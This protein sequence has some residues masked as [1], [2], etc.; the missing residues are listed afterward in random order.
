MTRKRPPGYELLDNERH[1]Y[2]QQAARWRPSGE[3]PRINVTTCQKTRVYRTELE[4]GGGV[5]GLFAKKSAVYH[6]SVLVSFDIK[7]FHDKP[8][9]LHSACDAKSYSFTEHGSQRGSLISSFGQIKF[10]P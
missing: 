2:V 10:L 1:H 5:R 9:P 6:L 4:G 7:Y 3:G 8:G